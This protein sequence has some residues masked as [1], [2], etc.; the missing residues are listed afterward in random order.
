MLLSTSQQ[1]QPGRRRGDVCRRIPK[2]PCAGTICAATRINWQPKSKNLLQ[3]ASQLKLGLNS[4]I[5]LDDDAKECA[6]MRRECPEVATLQLPAASKEIPRFLQHAWVFDHVKPADR[7]RSE[8]LA[9]VLRGAGTEPAR[10]AIQR[11]RPIHRQP[12]PGSS[13]RARHA[14]DAAA[15]RA[16]HPTHQPDELALRGDIRKAELSAALDGGE[17]DAFTVTVS[18]RFGSYGLVGLLLYKVE[19]AAF[20]RHRASC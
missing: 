8:A 10:S 17:L 13:V 16:A 6:E 5:F 9:N 20:N 14:G 3:L 19:E 7:R 12:A 15:S 18:D 11:S 1:E 4:F 2:C